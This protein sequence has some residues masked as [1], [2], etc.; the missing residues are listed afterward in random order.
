MS[1]F[2]RRLGLLVAAIGV[3][4]LASATYGFGAITAD[5]VADIGT[6][7][8][9]NALLGIED[10]TS[11]ETV[12]TS[13]QSNQPTPILELTNTFESDLDS[14]SVTVRTVEGDVGAENLSLVAP[15]SLGTGSSNAEKVGLYCTDE[16]G[17]A[18][19]VEVTFDITGTG[20]GLS[21]ETSQTVADIGVDCPPAPTPTP[22]PSPT[23]APSTTSSAN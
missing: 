9:E 3:V 14:V 13:T 10:V 7:N 21:V 15:S 23:P 4:V 12:V 17:A 2:Q 19:T 1:Q 5:R 8:D 16:N 22:T 18:G 20:E 11:D 6:A